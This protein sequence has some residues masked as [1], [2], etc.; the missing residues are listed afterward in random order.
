VVPAWQAEPVEAASS[1]SAASRASPETSVMLRLRVVGQPP[2][3]MT[4]DKHVAK[5]VGQPVV[6]PVP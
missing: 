1:G 3:G 6:Q 2:V 5:L 4:A